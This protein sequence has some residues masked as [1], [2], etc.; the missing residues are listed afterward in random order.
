MA[1]LNLELAIHKSVWLSPSPTQTSQ[2]CPEAPNDWHCF[3]GVISDTKSGP[4]L[5]NI[6]RSKMVGFLWPASAS[7][8]LLALAAASETTPRLA[9][10]GSVAGIKWVCALRASCSWFEGKRKTAICLG[11]AYRSS[12]GKPHMYIYCYFASVP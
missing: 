7:P 4:I 12:H 1:N 6:T 2:V 3:E 8:R 11:S 5:A 10:G 9:I